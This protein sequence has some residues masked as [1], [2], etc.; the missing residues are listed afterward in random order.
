MLQSLSRGRVTWNPGWVPVGRLDADYA[1]VQ[2][3]SARL[4]REV[5]ECW[6][7]SHRL[8]TPLHTQY[9]YM[10]IHARLFRLSIV[11]PVRLRTE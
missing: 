5:L 1:A 10:I 7:H 6:V 8:P 9:Q 3:S 2:S 11:C 4:E